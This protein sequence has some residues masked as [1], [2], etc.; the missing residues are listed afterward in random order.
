MIRRSIGLLAPEP[1]SL[2]LRGEYRFVFRDARTGRVT[3][4]ATYRNVVCVN[5]KSYLASWLNQEIGAN[6]TIYGAIGTGASPNPQSTDTQLVTELSR[7]VL[8]SSQ[9]TG[10]QVVM[11]FFWT[12][13]TG[14]GVLTEAGV[15]LA[16]SATANSGNLL[17]HVLI[18]ENKTSAETLTVE[19]TFTVGP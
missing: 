2:A 8:A 1:E 18:S 10:N 5:G 6:P 11:D 7:V 9:R 17:S 3:R 14:N 12:T 13:S 16:G 19:F 4:E 15:F